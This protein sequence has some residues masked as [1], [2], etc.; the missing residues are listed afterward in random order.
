MALVYGVRVQLFHAKTGRALIPEDQNAYLQVAN[1]YPTLLNLWTETVRSWLGMSH[2]GGV[3]TY[4]GFRFMISEG[5][6]TARCAVTSVL[7]PVGSDSPH[8]DAAN[9]PWLSAEQAVEQT[10]ASPGQ[11]TLSGEMNAAQR[12]SGQLVG[13]IGIL[14]EEGVPLLLG[15]IPGGLFLDDVD[16]LRM[17]TTLRLKN[18]GT[19]KTEFS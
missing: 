14:S 3:V 1:A 12:P 17:E 8:P 19:P 9:G 4:A 2:G 13:H 6:A 18:K 10:E 11:I 15:P 5:Y 16:R 7:P